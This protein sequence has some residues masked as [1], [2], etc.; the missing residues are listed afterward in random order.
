MSET[1]PKIVALTGGGGGAKLVY[2]LA[3]LVAPEKLTIIV[4][5]ADDFEHLSLHI[6][7]DLDAVMY[8]L[9]GLDNLANHRKLKDESWNMM[10]A[11]ARYGGP[12]WFQLGDRDMATKLLRTHWLREGYPYTWVA[13]ELSRRLGIR[14]T[15]LPMSEDLVRTM[16]QTETQEFPCQEYFARQQAQPAARAIRFAGIEAAQPSREVVSAIRTADLIILCPSNP[17]VSLD[18]IL[19]L[20]NVRRILAASRAPKIGISP[21]VGDKASHGPAGKLMAELGLVASPTGVAQHLREV[22]TGF[23]VDHVDQ[24]HQEAIT[25]LGLRTMVTGTVMVNK[26][27]RTNLAREVLEFGQKFSSPPQ[28]PDS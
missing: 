7:P 9:A 8:L 4:N 23:V 6:S 21:L 10:A 2:G 22:L 5:T 3:Q 13:G 27:D 14:C 28:S 18:P 1:T 25:D 19:A 15:I 24:A 26:E 20:P 11:L 17:L 12:T 16:I